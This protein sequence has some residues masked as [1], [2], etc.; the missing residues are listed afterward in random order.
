[1][2]GGANAAEAAR[3]ADGATEPA[4]TAGGAP[5]VDTD[6]AAQEDGDG[7]DATERPWT[8][9]ELKAQW[10]RDQGIAELLAQQGYAPGHAVRSAAEEQAEASRLAWMEARPRYK[11]TQR[12]QW[13]DE[14][15]G[16]ARKAQAKMEQSIHVLDMEYEQERESRVQQLTELRART[17]AREEAL[18]ALTQEAVDEYPP[19]EARASDGALR[20]ALS[21]IE[22]HLGPA[23]REL[24]DQ[25][26][27]GSDVRGKV[28]GGHGSYHIRA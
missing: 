13:A 12:M 26:P 22:R 9:D 24:Y 5:H 17:R 18:A 27:E 6:D 28:T 10:I 11:V 8:A 23:M 7:D 16:R 4:P 15:L 20:D 14:A 19:Q 25:T 3:S 21:A 2:G 1:M